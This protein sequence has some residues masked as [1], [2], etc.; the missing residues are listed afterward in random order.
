M[1][2]PG[3]GNLWKK[4]F[5]WGFASSIRGWVRNPAGGG[6]SRRQAAMLLEKQRAPKLQAYCKQI[7]AWPGLFKPQSH[8][9]SSKAT[10]PNLSQT[11]PLTRDHTLNYMSPW[12]YFQSHHNIPLPGP[13]RLI[14]IAQRKMHSVQ[15]QKSLVFSQS[16]NWLKVQSLFWDPSLYFNCN[17]L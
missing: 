7:W 14:A 9:C 1:K 17:I 2:H 12:G 16:Q 6:L 5:N 8:T 15:L 4:A 10:P 13:H 3:Q 11:A